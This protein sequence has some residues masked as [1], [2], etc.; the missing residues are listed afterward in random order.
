MGDLAVLAPAEADRGL[1]HSGEEPGLGFREHLEHPLT[2]G[3]DVET[4][5][6]PGN[7]EDEIGGQL[8]TADVVVEQLGLEVDG[9]RGGL[10]LRQLDLRYEQV[11]TDAS[12]NPLLDSQF[13]NCDDNSPC[14]GDEDAFPNLPVT[15]VRIRQMTIH[16]KHRNQRCSSQNLMA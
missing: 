2:G 9:L 4:V 15:H 11:E 7:A 1:D 3:L 14:N 5:P 6:L 13:L 10:E 12:F 8:V 16:G